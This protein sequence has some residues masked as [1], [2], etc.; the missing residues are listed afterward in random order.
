MA[1]AALLQWYVSK[2]KLEQEQSCSIDAVASDIC[3]SQN[4]SNF[5]LCYIL[6]FGPL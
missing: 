3:T 5:A 2:D 1:L 4:H 6:T